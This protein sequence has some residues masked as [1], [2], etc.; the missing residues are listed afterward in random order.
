MKIYTSRI[1]MMA[2]EIAKHLIDEKAV[3][4]TS[5]EMYEFRLDLE[6]VL[7]SYV[8]TDRRIHEEAQELI[9]R[10]GLDF[11]Q[12]GRIKR[13]VAKKY[14]FALG[15]DAIDWITDQMIEMLY[16]TTHVEEVWADNNDAKEK[17]PAT[18]K[19]TL[20]ANGKEIRTVT[21]NEQNGWT[22]TVSD[23]PVNEAGKRIFYLWTEATV[24]NYKLSS[25]TIEL[26]EDGKL[27]TMINEL[28]TEK[29]TPPDEGGPLGFG[30][31]LST[32][33]CIE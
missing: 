30:V 20:T 11:T 16:H 6:S 29:G 27:T 19:V 4:V 32:G 10:R 2:D 22:V 5:E 15:D 26:T 13:E 28:T 8:D 7:R 17:R 23:L 3:E 21:L 14:N 24:A 31:S 9:S 12:L 1:S 33:D 18:L 25:S